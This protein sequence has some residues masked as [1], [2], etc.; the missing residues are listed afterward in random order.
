MT[1]NQLGR[2]EIIG[3]LGKGAMGLVYLAR[4]P[5]I[6]RQ[7]ALKTF[8]LGFSAKDAD[9]EQ[10]KMRFLREA[11]SAGILSHPNIVTIH[12]V[13]VDDSGDFFIAMEYVKG[14]DLKLLMQQRQGKL[15]VRFVVDIVA[16]I[17]EGLDYAHSKGVVHRDIK[18]ANIIITADKQAKITDFGIAR[19]DASNL[20]VEGQL[21]GTPNYIAPEQIQGK[22]VDHRADIFSLGVM[23][24]EMTTGKKPFKGDN[25]T[26]V[27]HRIVYDA[28]TPPQQL[29]AGL[30]D[31]LVQ[32]LQKAMEK[33]PARRYARGQEMARD[34][35][36]VF[37][38]PGMRPEG[39][40]ASFL[41]PPTPV[42]TPQ[43]GPPPAQGTASQ[44]F[45]Q[46]AAAQPYPVSGNSG[47][48]RTGTLAGV[49]APAPPPP[50][51]A[52]AEPETNKAMI[53]GIAG[54]FLTALLAAGYMALRPAPDGGP[55]LTEAT[56]ETQLVQQY[57]PLV[58]K[59]KQA[60]DA[61]EPLRAVDYFDQA[62][63]FVP[64]DKEIRGLREQAEAMIQGA[65]MTVEEARLADGLARAA[66]ALSSGEYDDALVLARGVL[67]MEAENEQA[68]QL[69]ADAEAGKQRLKDV[70]DK[71][72]GRFIQPR[73]N[74]S[75][76]ATGTERPTAPAPAA[77]ETATLKIDFFSE[78][79]EGILTVFIGTQ[80][81]FHKNFKFTQES[82]GLIKRQVK[83][84]GS[85]SFTD[86]VDTG[87]NV[88][89]RVYVWLGGSETKT[90]ELDTEFGADEEKT[91]DI[92]VDRDGSVAIDLR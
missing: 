57:L 17:A 41:S 28:F 47:S 29:V 21:L 80:K 10:F 82:G 14:T 12:D 72:Q 49:P 92:R 63:V 64:G 59:G 19:V 8:R 75:S 33:D 53:W 43:L 11:Q 79:P 3:E 25:L 88:K 22:E 18:P 7:L 6:G 23:L 73:S 2:Y 36:S 5:I 83:S 48:V 68:L 27:T 56:P 58:R 62:L 70:K 20:T 77:Q 45:P 91:L 46:S 44:S 55:G 69:V 37:T 26:M 71:V 90:H 39:G 74:T 32:V 54:L 38:Q 16:Q 51:A 4:D 1:L 50:P 65:D 87:D 35:K 66:A 24:Y 15:D 81:F 13:V 78:L 84:S 30:P 31:R 86:S 40:T 61:G 89:V 85:L 67:D 42:A 52:S 60:M 34:L 9:A 76:G